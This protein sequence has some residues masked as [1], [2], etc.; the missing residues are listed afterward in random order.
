M[1]SSHFMEHRMLYGNRGIV[2]ERIT[3]YPSVMRN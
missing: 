1:R 2:P 3:K